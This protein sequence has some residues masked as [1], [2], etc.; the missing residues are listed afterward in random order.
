MMPLVDVVTKPQVQSEPAVYFPVVLEVGTEFE[1]PP[2]P[3]VGRQLRRVSRDKAWIDAGHLKVRSV[4]CEP[5]CVEEFVRR[6]GN[7]EFAVLDITFELRANFQ[8]MRAMTDG[9]HVA[10]AVLVLFKQLGVTIV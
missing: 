10:I 6:A 2:V 9:D 4:S 7:V 1:I 3:D 5:Y 8:I